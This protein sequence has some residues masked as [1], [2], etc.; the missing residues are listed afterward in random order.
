MLKTTIQRLLLVLALLVG[1]NW[2]SIAMSF[3]EGIHHVEKQND[4]RKKKHKKKKDENSQNNTDKIKS[5]GEIPSK[6]YEVL[7]HIK[8]NGKPIDGYV[9]GRKFGNYEKLLPREDE[10]GRKIQYQEWD[11]NPKVEGKNRGTERIVT[12]SDGKAYYTNDHYRSFQ[13][14]QNSKQTSKSNHGKF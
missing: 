14:I 11:V 2:Q 5:N 12:G 6:V 10:E 3:S 9:G 4:F 1:F 7:S 13:V 8:S